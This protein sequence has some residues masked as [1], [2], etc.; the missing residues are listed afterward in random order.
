MQKENQHICIAELGSSTEAHILRG[1]LQTEGIKVFIFDDIV[2]YESGMPILIHVPFE[3][4]EEA[5]KV[6]DEFYKGESEV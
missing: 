1:L 5:Q 4:K 3:Q 6:V 2:A